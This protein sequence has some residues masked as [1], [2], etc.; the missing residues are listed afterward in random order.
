MQTLT[1]VLSIVGAVGGI[2]GLAS[3]FYVR[4]QT[5][6]MQQQ[7]RRLVRHDDS[8]EGWAK[9]YDEAASA[10]EKICSGTL[11]MGPGKT[12]PAYQFAFP[13]AALR[14]RIERYLGTRNFWGKFRPIC[15]TGEQLQNPVLQHTIKEVLETVATFRTEHTDFARSIGLLP[16]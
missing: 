4:K 16:K 1:V 3:L 15:P 6:V 2:S 7:M 5:M 12:A 14:E 8:A 9:E 11:M 13:D 10:L